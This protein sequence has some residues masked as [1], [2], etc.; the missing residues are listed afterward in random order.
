MSGET[1]K[2]TP[3]CS[4]PIGIVADRS[5]FLADIA[6]TIETARIDF[7]FLMTTCGANEKSEPIE[8]VQHDGDFVVLRWRALA[9]ELEARAL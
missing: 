6:H 4:Y 5:L 2:K 8:S 7:S 9:T 3:P 1:C